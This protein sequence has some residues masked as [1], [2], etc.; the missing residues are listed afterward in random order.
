MINSHHSFPSLKKHLQNTSPHQSKK[1]AT[2]IN[3]NE[4]MLAFAC[5]TPQKALATP[6]SDIMLIMVV[7]AYSTKEQV[8]E[9]LQLTYKKQSK[10]TC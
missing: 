2:S 7:E 10:E 5:G 6:N 3:D 4:S 9:G 8:Q 1:K